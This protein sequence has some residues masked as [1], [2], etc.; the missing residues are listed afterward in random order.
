MT[1]HRQTPKLFSAEPNRRLPLRH[2]AKS[3]FPS[4]SSPNRLSASTTNDILKKRLESGSSNLNTKTRSSR[5]RPE[6]S[7]SD[8]GKENEVPG[9]MTPILAA[10]NSEDDLNKISGGGSGIGNYSNK[11][12]QTIQ[13][14]DESG[15]VSSPTTSVQAINFKN[16]LSVTKGRK[17]NRR[18]SAFA[19]KLKLR[20]DDESG[21][22]DDSYANNDEDGSMNCDNNNNDS[23]KEIEEEEEEE[24][25][26]DSDDYDDESECSGDTV[27]ALDEN[28]PTPPPPNAT[29]EELNQYYWKLC[30]GA[31]TDF[32]KLTV[33]I[34]TWSAMRSAPAKSW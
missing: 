31:D 7:G 13:P 1:N 10:K 25:D 28:L 15:E 3:L 27:V 30:Y 29:Q 32:E 16:N 26:S 18:A 5:E 8:D 34:G 2:G 14:R 17:K 9:S 22:D 12:K 20:F 11:S 4:R 19:G 23:M 6:S 24:D 33:E 21:M